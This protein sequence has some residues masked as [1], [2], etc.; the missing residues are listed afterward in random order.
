MPLEMRP[1]RPL[2]ANGA[3]AP[4]QPSSIASSGGAVPTP[5]GGSPGALPNPGGAGATANGLGAQP[6]ASSPLGGRRPGEGLAG[7]FAN[8]AGSPLGGTQRTTETNVGLGRSIGARNQ[9]ERSSYG[10]LGGVMAKNTTDTGAPPLSRSTGGGGTARTTS[11]LQTMKD[12]SA[13]TI[14]GLASGTAG[15]PEGSSLPP[16]GGAAPRMPGA[17]SGPGAAPRGAQPSGIVP[18]GAPQPQGTGPESTG[19]FPPG[20][21]VGNDAARQET[22]L[23]AGSGGAF[24]G[25]LVGQTQDGYNIYTNAQ[26]EEWVETDRGWVFAPGANGSYVAGQSGNGTPQT[27]TTRRGLTTGDRQERPMPPAGGGSSP[28]GS[29]SSGLTAGGGG[30]AGPASP[31]PSQPAAPSGYSS[32]AGTIATSTGQDPFLI[33]ALIDMG[34]N[35]NAITA[36][37]V[38]GI[39]DPDFGFSGDVEWDD[40]ED[41][42]AGKLYS[43][44]QRSKENKAKFGAQQGQR[45]VDQRIEQL[46]GRIGQMSPPGIDQGVIEGRVTS[47]N[48]RFAEQQSKSLGAQLGGLAAAGFSPEAQQAAGYQTMKETGLAAAGQESNTRMAGEQANLQGRLLQYQQKIGLLQN[49]LT[50]PM[51]SAQQAAGLQ[52][53][54]AMLQ[55]QASQEKEMQTWQTNQVTG[56]DYL[57][58]LGSAG[59]QG[60]IG[61]G[62][63]ALG[64][65]L[66]A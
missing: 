51:L 54:I 55:A 61:A 29:T 34:I 8:D 52:Q 28:Y 59:L 50:I 5:L 37:G 35:P 44:G 47:D 1:R 17:V 62:A 32:Q 63:N 43:A 10:Q 4:A 9:A 15:V 64:A 20:H 13:S 66:G 11:P 12:D 45:D 16:L 36:D 38:R 22:G 31:P 53:A 56:W 48:R 23:F 7:P 40:L 33:Q 27:S 39:E 18:A 3:A 26:G 58:D 14:R 6:P 46:L 19:R 65:K 41:P 24:S 42:E 60:A 2:F 25:V 57:R 21:V 49:M 30:Q